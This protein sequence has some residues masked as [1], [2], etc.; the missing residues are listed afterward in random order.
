MKCDEIRE[1]LS[2]YVDGEARGDEGRAA[3]EHLA[4]CGACRDFVQRMSVVGAGVEK[5]EGVVPRDFRETLFARMERDGLL[6]RRRSLYAYSIRWAAV[7]LAAAAALALFVLTSRDAGIKEPAPSAQRTPAAEVGA[8]GV[9]EGIAQKGAEAPVPGA[10]T[11]T[12]GTSVADARTGAGL[13]PEEREI[14]AHLDVLEDPA[15]MDE[16]SEIDD[17]EIDEPDGRSRG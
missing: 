5:V 6:P 10:G 2:S 16:P 14:V 12:G 7:P 15:A 8:P 17:L 13:T 9:R 11:G 1:I 4:A 3:E